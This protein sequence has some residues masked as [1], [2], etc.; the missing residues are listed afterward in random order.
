M[1]VKNI[2][3]ALSKQ[4]FIEQYFSVV[5]F[6]M[7]YTVVLRLRPCMKSWKVAIQMRAT[8]Q[9]FLVFL[10][11]TVMQG[12]LFWDCGWNPKMWPMIQMNASEQYSVS[13]GTVYVITR[14]F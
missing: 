9:Y 4:T 10:L 1:T 11:L 14:W 13:C 2:V 6:I 3:I 5:L 8:E 12:S 7:L